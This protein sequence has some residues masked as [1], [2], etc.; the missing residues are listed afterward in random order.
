MEQALFCVKI[1][2]EEVAVQRMVES[3]LP[4]LCIK[5]SLPRVYRDDELVEAMR[6]VLEMKDTPT[7]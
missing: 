6:A 7:P 5:H 1:E 3:G 2:C 4:C